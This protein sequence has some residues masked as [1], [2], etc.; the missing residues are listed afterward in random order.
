MI[1]NSLVEMARCPT[2]LVPAIAESPPLSLKQ[3]RAILT[4]GRLLPK[5]SAHAKLAI[6]HAD[7]TNAEL[8]L[9]FAGDMVLAAREAGADLDERNHFESLGSRL[10]DQLRLELS[11]STIM[12]RHRE[13]I[14][15]FLSCEDIDETS[16]SPYCERMLGHRTTGMIGAYCAEFR[17]G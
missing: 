9:Q 12:C 14:E 3:V 1:N 11:P 7:M 6:L 13:A 10:E 5:I 4:V 2:D 15:S 17:M 8:A 16:R